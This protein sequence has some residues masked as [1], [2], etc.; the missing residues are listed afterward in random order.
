MQWQKSQ[1][2]RS[3]A[4]AASEV[5]TPC[6]ALLVTLPNE[7]TVSL[8]SISSKIEPFLYAPLVWTGGN[9]RLTRSVRTCLAW[10]V[11]HIVVQASSSWSF[12]LVLGPVSVFQ[13]VPGQLSRIQTLYFKLIDCLW[14]SYPSWH[15]E[16][17]EGSNLNTRIICPPARCTL[18]VASLLYSSER[19]WFKSCQ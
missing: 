9:A 16:M 2:D 3:I 18:I 8:V 12:S 4:N 14:I 1:K 5:C 11:W 17:F 13:C 19:S 15:L 7:P 10:L 6:A